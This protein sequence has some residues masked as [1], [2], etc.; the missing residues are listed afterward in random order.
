MK[1]S[2]SKSQKKVIK[3]FNKFCTDGIFNKE[4]DS[5]A[6]HQGVSETEGVFEMVYKEGP[7]LVTDLSQ[8]HKE[9]P[10]IADHISLKSTETDV[11]ESITTASASQT[12]EGK[13]PVLAYNSFNAL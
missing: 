7:T 3:R 2:P 9:N 10:E 11:P 4:R 5:E 6:N 12:N 8:I 13:W 1:F